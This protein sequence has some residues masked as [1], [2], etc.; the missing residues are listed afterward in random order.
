MAFGSGPRSLRSGARGAPLSDRGPR[1]PAV[2]QRA[3]NRGREAAPGAGFT[4]TQGGSW[5]RYRGSPGFHSRAPPPPGELVTI[6]KP[7]QILGLNASSVRRWMADGFSAGGQIGPG[8]AWQI[9]ITD[10]L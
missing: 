6:R 7:A 9:R 5:R 2:G 10:E 1:K 4:G 3:G 8:G